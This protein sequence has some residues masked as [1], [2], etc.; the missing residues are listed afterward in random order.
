MHLTEL[1]KMRT[2][3]EI[4]KLRAEKAEAETEQLREG[5]KASVRELFGDRLATNSK[6]VAMLVELV[7]E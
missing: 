2:R 4:A 5:I 7:G 1:E 3:Y 6:G